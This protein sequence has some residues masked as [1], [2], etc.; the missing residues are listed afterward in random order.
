MPQAGEDLEK[1]NI[2]EALHYLWQ[3]RFLVDAIEAHIRVMIS[4]RQPL[5]VIGKNCYFPPMIENCPEADRMDEEMADNC[6]VELQES[7]GAFM[8]KYK[9]IRIRL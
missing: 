6:F 4:R 2:I 8:V 5:K 9:G 1:V 3:Y 7:L